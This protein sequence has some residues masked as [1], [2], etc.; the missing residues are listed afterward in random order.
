MSRLQNGKNKL[1]VF[2]LCIVLMFF[3]GCTQ[4]N[5]VAES[6]SDRE[7]IT[8]TDCV[9]R[10]V[11]IPKKVE[12]VASIFATSGHIATILGKGDS[13]VA[14]SNGLT[15]DLLLHEVCPHIKDALVAKG[16]GHFNIEEL[17]K[18]NPD[19]VFFSTDVIK[20]HATEKKINQL[21]IPYL[22]VEYKNIEEQK[23][24]VEMIGKV[25]GEESKAQSYNKYYDDIVAMVGERTKDIGDK[26]RVRVYHAINEVART[27]SPNTLPADWT[28]VAGAKNVSIEEDHAEG[29]EDSFKLVNTKFFVSFEQICLWNPDV[30]IANGNGIDLYLQSKDQF[31]E[32]NAVLNDKVYL[33]PNGVSRWGHP[34]SIETPLAILWTAK[35]LYPDKFQDI[36]MVKETKRFYKEFFNY[37]LGNEKAE[38]ILSGKGMRIPKG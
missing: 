1:I 4:N 18:A 21:G 27:D 37:D 17:I 20:D 19:V 2:C 11:E 34:Y 24:A 3:T 9:G 23:Y 16:G 30:I 6:N 25:L 32:V 15:R 33:L 28:K 29:L 36:D 35:T 7:M 14:I 13:I 12:R 26:E 8:I 38:Q 22:I 5:G 31:K 10:E